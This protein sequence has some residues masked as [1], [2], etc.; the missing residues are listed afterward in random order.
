MPKLPD[1]F[2]PDGTQLTQLGGVE[3]R[4]PAG[5][6]PDGTVHAPFVDGDGRPLDKPSPMEFPD[7]VSTFGPTVEFA[8]IDGVVDHSRPLRT[9]L[10]I[11]ERHENLRDDFVRNMFRKSFSKDSDKWAE[12]EHISNL[13][14]ISTDVVKNRFPEMK[15]TMAAAEHDPRRWRY[16]N[17]GLFRWVEES[18]HRATFAMKEQAS[19]FSLKIRQIGA[20]HDRLGEVAG[21]VTTPVRVGATTIPVTPFMEHV[22]APILFAGPNA[23]AVAMIASGLAKKLAVLQEKTKTAKGQLELKAAGKE[24]EEAGIPKEVETELSPLSTT[25]GLGRLAVYG[26]QF[27]RSYKAVDSLS[28]LG[29]DQV[30]LD[31]EV[32]AAELSGDERRINAARA[33]QVRGN[34]EVAKLEAEVNHQVYYNQSWPEQI[35]LD[36]M[37]VAASQVGTIQATLAGAGVLGAVGLIGGGAVGAFTGGPS[38]AVRGGK[39]G[40]QLMSW[41]G[42]RSFAFMASFERERG[43][44]Y[45]EFRKVKDDDG[46][47]MDQS[48]A[49]T[50]SGVYGAIA[51]TAE[52]ATLGPELSVLGPLGQAIKN[53]VGIK[54]GAKLLGKNWFRKAMVRFGK[55]WAR[56]AALEGIEE[57]SQEYAQ[58]VIGWLGKN[59][60]S[61]RLNEFKMQ[62]LL[63]RATEAIGKGALGGGPMVAVGRVSN[64]VMNPIIRKIEDS[65]RRSRLLAK[66]HADSLKAGAFIASV[67]GLAKNEGASK[68]APTEIARLV[69]IE[70]ERLGVPGKSF[71]IDP[72]KLDA[73]VQEHATNPG[74]ELRSLLGDNAEDRIKT[75]NAKWIDEVG[76]KTTLEVPMDEFLKKWGNKPYVEE[77]LQDL[78]VNPEHLKISEISEGQA[79]IAE[80]SE[81]LANEQRGEDQEL[82][83]SVS[84]KERKFSKLKEDKLVDLGVMTREEARLQVAVDRAV[85]RTMAR[86]YGDRNSDEVFGYWSQQLETEDRIV[87]RRV[88]QPEKATSKE[89]RRLANKDNPKK[90]YSVQDS[91]EQ[92]MDQLNQDTGANLGPSEQADSKFLAGESVSPFPGGDFD[93]INDHLTNEGLMKSGERVG[94]LR[95]AWS[96][97]AREGASGQLQT[98]DRIENEILPVL[99]TVPG[100]EHLSVPESIMDAR[101]AQEH[102]EAR[103]EASKEKWESHEGEEIDT[104]FDP[105]ALETEELFQDDERVGVTPRARVRITRDGVKNAARIIF[106]KHSDLSSFIH[107]ST[108]FYFEMMGDLAERSVEDVADLNSQLA[109]ARRGKDKAALRKQIRLIEGA[110]RDYRTM[111]EWLGA[112]GRATLTT[113]QKEKFAKAFELYLSEGKAPSASLA[114]AF[115]SFRLWFRRIYKQTMSAYFGDIELNDEIRGV[116]DRM[117]ATD[118]EI[119][120]VQE[121]AGIRGPMVQTQEQLGMSDNEWKKYLDFYADGNRIIAQETRKR[122]TEARL[123]AAKAFRTAEFRKFKTESEEEW[124]KRR[125]VR[126][127]RHIR[128]GETVSSDGTVFQRDRTGMMDTDLAEEIAGSKYRGVIESLKGRLTREGGLHPHDVAESMGYAGD[129]PGLAMFAE[130]AEGPVQTKDK[131]VW[132]NDRARDLMLE[133]N[134]EIEGEIADMAKMV[135]SIVQENEQLKDVW[136]RSYSKLRAGSGLVADAAAKKASSQLIGETK[137][138]DL[139]PNQHMRRMRM[140]SDT[141]AVA[142]AKGDFRRAAAAQ[143]KERLAYYMWKD[144][145]KAEKQVRKFN[146][147]LKRLDKLKTRETLAIA[148]D[149]FADTASQILSALGRKKFM[150]QSQLV[151]TKPLDARLAELGLRQNELSADGDTQRTLHMDHVGVQAIITKQ[152]EIVGGGDWK[153]L[154]MSEM[155]TIDGALRELLKMSIDEESI[156]IDGRRVKTDNVASDIHDD[157]VSTRPHKEAPLKG[158]SRYVANYYTSTIEPRELSRKLG[159]RGDEAF[160]G[161]YLRAERVEEEIHD[162]VGGK[163]TQML[164]DLRKSVNVHEVMTDLEGVSFGKDI[165]QK[166][167]RD[168]LHMYLI[169]AMMGSE[170]GEQRVLGGYGWEPDAVLGWLDRNMTKEEV[171]FVNGI[172]E[173]MD[174]SLYPRMAKAYKAEKGTVPTKIEPKTTHLR[175]GTLTGGYFPAKYDR[176]NSRTAGA[177][178]QSIDDYNINAGALTM[179]RSFTQERVTNFSDVV[180]L[181]WN[182]LSSHITSVAHWTAY[183]QFIRQSSQLLQHPQFKADMIERVGLEN[184]THLE[185]WI[186][187]VATAGASMVPQHLRGVFNIL[188]LGAQSFMYGT[189]A[190]S[191]AIAAADFINPIQAIFSG[192]FKGGKEKLH[193]A[194]TVASAYASMG[195][196]GHVPPG[197]GVRGL[198]QMF[199]RGDE[200]ST[201]LR[202][203]AKSSKRLVKEMLDL[204][205][206]KG[207]KLTNLAEHESNEIAFWMLHAMD[208]MSS[209]IVWNAAYD[210]ALRRKGATEA[211]AVA[212]ADDVVIGTMPVMTRLRMAAIL[213]DKSRLGLT[214]VFQSYY[215][216]NLNMAAAQLDPVLAELGLAKQIGDKK[217][218]RSARKKA[219]Y[220]VASVVAMYSVAGIFG[221]LFAGHGPEE[222][223][224]LPQYATRATIGTALM[225][226]PYIGTILGPA[227]AYA[228]SGKKALPGG[229]GG[230]LTGA[231]EKLGGDLYNIA[232]SADG[233]KQLIAA[234]TAIGMAGSPVGLG[235]LASPL[236]RRSAGVALDDENRTVPQVFN[237]ILFGGERKGTPE[238]PITVLDSILIGD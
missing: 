234:M 131:K 38:G 109:V 27:V 127:W 68:T 198:R 56:A 93:I 211:K 43:S 13:T 32:R 206:P 65:G 229:R 150:N 220:A 136:M 47:V 227:A 196:L 31:R 84:P 94:G 112:K 116:F 107:E 97:L 111:V 130:I 129:S 37:E 28:V 142:A 193:L 58:F 90:I 138:A 146:D 113:A 5:F 125:D 46:K 95:H 62:E 98:W 210:I 225:S 197:I 101:L 208:R 145:T 86:K 202:S 132:L 100:L 33:A 89:Q 96:L 74:A 18:P 21:M 187:D 91:F 194:M 238:T 203:R 200:K 114:K 214:L 159:P 152:N 88:V 66:R 161:E 205:G 231:T 119:Q 221:E 175:N 177:R 79:D 218:A 165:I 53:G 237:Q 191:A 80:L 141:A 121:A 51:A 42:A 70:A 128:L 50:F 209:T 157:L 163:L 170:S 11:F 82:P 78:V 143:V 36:V 154:T 23:G 49:D 236:A 188:G 147:F 17:P 67:A 168:R 3:S 182:N 137:A 181:D 52:V 6:I 75:A 222:D 172:W 61:G 48:I 77:L 118:R 144:S 199:E 99:R 87:E 71:W 156:V 30:F 54:A 216:K 8:E 26:D 124:S 135:K 160:W 195:A 15:A 185:G 139:R 85:I 44:A 171:R 178:K 164:I 92:V 16:E 213:R 9:P 117:L 148:G 215:I 40:L 228:I 162:E 57:G 123:R 12:I 45:L 122:V 2:I 151:E 64:A 183:A 103:L 189:V 153:Q 207:R 105:D 167:R 166:P 184:Y 35:G 217:G 63:P 230:A 1:G 169:A 41:I 7:P 24:I 235:L 69:E 76:G 55:D 174:K 173:I 19:W 25:E 34:S 22:V 60:S 133:R 120:L 186:R 115:E 20:A 190:V 126:A 104:S 83:P 14:G 176:I 10:E 29:S 179:K 204:A 223:E 219:V 59:V 140:S 155:A 106:N 108:H 201:E 102:A 158:E 73:V 232:S 149:E 39:R 224:T 233:D 192:R 4:L 72:L 212:H 81:K 226:F 134:P 110:Q 180:D